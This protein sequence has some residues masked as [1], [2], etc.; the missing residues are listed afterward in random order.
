V[1]DAPDPRAIQTTRK[2]GIDISSHRARLFRTSDF[3][4]FDLILAMDDSHYRNILKRCRSDK[5][6][7]KVFYMLDSIAPGM[8]EEVQDPWYHDLRAFEDV[9]QLLDKASR[10]WVDKLKKRH[11]RH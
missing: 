10:A 3:D 9:F 5:D 11:D 1:G 8:Q 7:E 2:R 4:D 6:R